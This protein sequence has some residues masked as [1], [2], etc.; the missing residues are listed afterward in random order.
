MYDYGAQ[1][2]VEPG[3]T[4]H[5]TTYWTEPPAAEPGDYVASG[6]LIG[7]TTEPGSGFE[8]PETAS[9]RFTIEGD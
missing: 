4:L 8:C 1:D 7:C 6:W 3:E 2:E 5:R 9:A